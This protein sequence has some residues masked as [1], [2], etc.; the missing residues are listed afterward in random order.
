MGNYPKFNQTKIG[1]IGRIPKEWKVYRV[2][3]LFMVET[4]TTPSTKRRDYWEDGRIDWFTPSDLSKLKGK[5]EIKNSERKINEKALR[6]NN[7]I[8]M[9]PGSIIMSTRAPVGY[10]SVLQDKATFNQGC[11]G[12]I[13]KDEKNISTKFYCY[14][15]LN[16]NQELQNLSSGSTFKELSKERL[17]K[18]K[19]LLPPFP[20]QKKIAEILSTVD[21]AIAKVDEAIEKSQR[22]KKCLMEELLTKGIGHKEFKETEIGRIPKGWD[23]RK[24]ANIFALSSGKSRPQEFSEI[25]TT[26]MT[27]P[28]YGGNGILGYANKF[29]ISDETIV[30]GRVGEY[31]G[32]IHKTSKNSWI[33]DNA[34]YATNLTSRDIDLNFLTSYLIF[35]NLNKFKKKS[36]QPLMTQT[37]VYSI[38]ILLPPLPEQ[39]KI[40]EILSTVD[41]KLELLRKK[42]ARF[43]SIKR[44]LMNNL[45][46]GKKRV[47]LIKG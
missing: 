3:D 40:T 37:I 11:K 41:K 24:L 12:L 36:G 25:Q 35:L 45:L 2:A 28:I 4:G 30:I 10:V 18:F 29:M 16:K 9:P 8:L 32:S 39:Q 47:R 13:I 33:T 17:E 34:L 38:A 7:L 6:E 26:K 42:K 31:C 44:G 14:Y 20:E 46:T 23:V 15:L 5:I 22:L 21:D 27:Y 43:E 19:I 1:K